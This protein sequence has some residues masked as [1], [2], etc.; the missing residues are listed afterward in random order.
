MKYIIL[1][2]LLSESLFS[3]IQ[4]TRN[5]IPIV[6]ND[7]SRRNSLF[8]RTDFSPELSRGNG[9]YKGDMAW[10]FKLIGYSE[11]YRFDNGNAI[12]FLLGHELN[13][14][15][16]NDIAFNPRKATWEENISYYANKDD[17]SYSIGIFHRCKHDI[18]ITDRTTAQEGYYSNRVIILNGLNASYNLIKNY[19]NFNIITRVYG[20]YYFISEDYKRPDN[21]F[22]TF[23]DLIGS[24]RV[25]SAIDYSLGKIVDL[26]LLTSISN[27]ISRKKSYLTDSKNNIDARIEF[28]I[29]L[30]GKKNRGD[31]FF[32]YETMFE[33]T[34][35]VIP[36]QTT[37]WQIGIRLRPEIFR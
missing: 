16:Y 35:Q 4:V 30:K 8:E 12:A 32:A 31:F 13:S 23:E 9:S 18:D 21:A 2:I 26:R 17:F 19:D 7:T 34:T 1:F 14:N 33:E 24:I 10:S 28:A 11:V 29:T 6:D 37:F 3:Q 20:E 22:A 5:I 36:H 25:S 15:P 27:S